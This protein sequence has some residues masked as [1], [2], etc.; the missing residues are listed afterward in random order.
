MGD[1]APINITMRKVGLA[2]YIKPDG[3]VHRNFLIRG[4]GAFL[5]K[6]LAALQALQNLPTGKA[7]LD[8][9]EQIQVPNEGSLVTIRKASTSSFV[10]MGGDWPLEFDSMSLD[11]QGWPETQALVAT[12]QETRIP[13]SAASDA[14][15]ALAGSTRGKPHCSTV[16]WDPDAY[17][18][19]PN[20]TD[21]GR[22]LGLGHEL[23]HAIHNGKGENL[24]AFKDQNDPGSTQEES[25]AI[26]AGIWAGETPSENALRDDWNPK[27]AH[28]TSHASLCGGTTPSAGS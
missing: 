22:V 9:I 8:A 12:N 3:K 2:Y 25:R 7:I 1:D 15:S 10:T 4:D 19:E 11:R 16:F 24:M 13:L 23:C 28:R 6:V 27:F 14:K 21:P 26:G 17:N 18:S 20:C 5:D